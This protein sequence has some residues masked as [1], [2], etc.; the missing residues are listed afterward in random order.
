MGVS[1]TIFKVKKETDADLSD[2]VFTTGAL[3]VVKLV[4]EWIGKDSRDLMIFPKE[5]NKYLKDLEKLLSAFLDL[6]IV[7]LHDHINILYSITSMHY[8]LR[9]V[10][11]KNIHYSHYHINLS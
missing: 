2:L 7:D 5:S 3:P 1:V 11:Q 4:E 6:E 9:T 10:G 8:N